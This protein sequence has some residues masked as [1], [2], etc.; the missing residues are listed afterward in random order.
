ML[1]AL[2]LGLLALGT[3]TAIVLASYA[4]AVVANAI[5]TRLRQNGM[6]KGMLVPEEETRDIIAAVKEKNPA[7]G[8]KLDNAIGDGDAKME[9]VFDGK[10]AVRRV[11]AVKAEDSSVDDFTC[12]T[13][14]YADGRIKQY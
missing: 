8:K 14:F 9:F 4:L 11:V 10:N 3:F 2:I 1:T 13:N 7:L 6:A 12:V 5:I